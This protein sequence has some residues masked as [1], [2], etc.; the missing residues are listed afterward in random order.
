MSYDTLY[1]QEK[2]ASIGQTITEHM[3]GTAKQHAHTFLLDGLR[4]QFQ[5]VLTALSLDITLARL[6]R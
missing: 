5:N 6:W 2:L 3:L 1:R 4:V